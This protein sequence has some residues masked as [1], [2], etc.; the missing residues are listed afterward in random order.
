MYGHTFSFRHNYKCFLFL[1]NEFLELTTTSLE[2]WSSYFASKSPESL[3]TQIAVS[4][5]RV[6]FSLGL[7]WGPG[8]LIFNKFP[9]AAAGDLRTPL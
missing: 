8:I 7:E 2:Y 1:L 6:V 9:G 4:I 5:P 3:L